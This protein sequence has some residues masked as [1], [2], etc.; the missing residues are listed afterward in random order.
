[1]KEGTELAPIRPTVIADRR[2]FYCV[3]HC[4]FFGGLLY[5][6]C[7]SAL[8]GRSPADFIRLYALHLLLKD[9]FRVRQGP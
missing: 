4:G 1:M 5:A 2:A 3:R 8:I 7:E 9:V 6:C